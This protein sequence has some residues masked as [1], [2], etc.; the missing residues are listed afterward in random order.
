MNTRY[1]SGYDRVGS[2]TEENVMITITHNISIIWRKFR[3][4]IK[5]KKNRKGSFFGFTK[6][7]F[8]YI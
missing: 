2:I 6:V 1:V 3:C 5:R 7:K 8:D 4:L